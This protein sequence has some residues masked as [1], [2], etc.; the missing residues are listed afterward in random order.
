MLSVSY[1]KNIYC[2]IGISEGRLE[3]GASG[4]LRS[5][6]MDTEADR[7]DYQTMFAREQGAV[8]APTAALH[9]TQRLL[10]A[11]SKTARELVDAFVPV[12]S[13]K[14]QGELPKAA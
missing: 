9:F 6:P 11:L 8:A 4:M 13:G 10:D 1:D 5:L 12:Q 7:T 14:L 3:Q 2:L